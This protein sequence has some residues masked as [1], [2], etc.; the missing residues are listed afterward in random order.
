MDAQRLAIFDLDGT[1]MRGAE[2]IPGAI[3]AVRRARD[4]GRAVR[5][6]T[7]NSGASTQDLLNRLRSAGFEFEEQEVY[8][9]AT[10]A[11]HWCR[12]A[13]IQRVYLIGEP[14]LREV[15]VGSGFDVVQ[16]GADPQRAVF[17][18]H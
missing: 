10:A 18:D 9:T 13:G 2:A 5:V 6:L 1:L 15:F 16:A 11:A 4:A 8:G 14:A 12:D 3:E 17:P 7:N